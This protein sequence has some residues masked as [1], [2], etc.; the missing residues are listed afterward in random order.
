MRG[1]VDS[2]A[3][4][5]RQ[6]GTGWQAAGHGVADS[7]ACAGQSARGQISKDRI[8]RQNKHT[9]GAE[10]VGQGRSISPYLCVSISRQGGSVRAGCAWLCACGA[11]GW[12]VGVLV[13]SISSGVPGQPCT[14][15]VRW[16]RVPCGRLDVLMS[17]V[18]GTGGVLGRACAALERR[19]VPFS[20]LRLAFRPPVPS[21]CPSLLPMA[22][23]LGPAAPRAGRSSSRPSAPPPPPGR[24]AALTA[25]HGVVDSGARGGRQRSV[26]W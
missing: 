21:F 16:Q 10:C 7:G 22:P 6:R 20:L 26:G 13:V 25:G 19:S 18:G 2:G 1:V 11:S 5:V 23:S 12:D 4:G 9:R 15:R 24:S 8:L 17:R 14:G 3:W